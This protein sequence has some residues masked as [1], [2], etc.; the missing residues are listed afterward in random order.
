MEPSDKR[1]DLTVLKV[2]VRPAL[3]RGRRRQQYG[4]HKLTTGTR[5]ADK[6]NLG[7]SRGFCRTHS[8]AA[9]PRPNGGVEKRSVDIAKPRSKCCAWESCDQTRARSRSRA[10]SGRA[11]CSGSATCVPRIP[12]KWSCV[13]DKLGMILGA[14]APRNGRWPRIP[15]ERSPHG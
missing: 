3:G 13:K 7:K 15:R 2:R 11:R 10:C 9:S 8:R 14:P 6:A 4:K 1:W 12:A 5:P